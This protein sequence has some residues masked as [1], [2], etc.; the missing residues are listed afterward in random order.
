M[1][2][3][4]A[5]G[6]PFWLEVQPRFGKALFRQH[7]RTGRARVSLLRI[8]RSRPDSLAAPDRSQMRP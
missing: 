6:D 8:K 4:P 3:V 1:C 7:M 5:K 2:N